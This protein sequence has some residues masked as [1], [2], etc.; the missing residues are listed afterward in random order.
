MVEIRKATEAD[1]PLVREL[2]GVV[3]PE[4]YKEIL[5][6][7]QVGYMMNWMYSV[8]SLHKQMAEEGHI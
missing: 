5:S 2:A 8:E 1:I 3:F 7:E 4:T 6:P